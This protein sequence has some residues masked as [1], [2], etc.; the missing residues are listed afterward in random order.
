MTWNYRVV[1]ESGVYTVREVF[2]DEQSQPVAYTT[3]EISPA[4]NDREEFLA[5]WAHYQEAMS[6]PVLV[7]ENEKIVGR[8]VW[9]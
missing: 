4:G 9:R 2:Y 6:K 5:S 7:A 1:K 8:E 3:C